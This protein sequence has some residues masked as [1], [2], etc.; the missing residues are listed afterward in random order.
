[1]P[2][3][4]FDFPIAAPPDRVFAAISTPTGL[5]Q[6][7]TLSSAGQAVTDATFALGFGPEYQWTARVIRA[8]PGRAFEL[9]LVT[10]MADWVGTR[11][12]FELEPL[13]GGRTRVRFHHSGWADAGDHFRT[14]AFC[15]AMYL[16]VMRRGLEYGERIP[17]AERLVV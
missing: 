10:A 13:D 12:G 11:V 1:M 16:R 6:W 17:Y 5:D 15:W 3:I 7:W 9:E 14:T 4:R 8:E 2:E